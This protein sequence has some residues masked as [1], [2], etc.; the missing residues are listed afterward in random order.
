VDG[1]RWNAISTVPLC[2]PDF[3]AK[4][5]FQ[6]HM[7]DQAE[8][9]QLMR[10][11]EQLVLPQSVGEDFNPKWVLLLWLDVRTHHSNDF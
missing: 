5:F 10:D 11:I 4:Y 8:D 7:G 6:P 2:I 9:D 1:P 3:N